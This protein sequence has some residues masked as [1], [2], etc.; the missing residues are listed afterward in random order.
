LYDVVAFILRGKFNGNY[1]INY[2]KL[3]YYFYIAS[4]YYPLF[5][6]FALH[7]EHS[8]TSRFKHYFYYI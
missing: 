6:V 7:I 1:F 2:S 5:I 8:H 4:N 3:F